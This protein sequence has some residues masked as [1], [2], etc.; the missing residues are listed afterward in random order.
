MLRLIFTALAA[1]TLAGCDAA[2]VSR[3]EPSTSA[4]PQ[5][6]SDARFDAIAAWDEFEALL[7]DQYAYADRFGEEALNAQMARSRAVAAKARSKDEA[8]RIFH[9][10]AL[11]FADPH[12]LVGP[13]DE[14][15]YAVIMTSADLDI[16]FDNGAFLVADVRAGSSAEVAGIRSGWGV[17]EVD[18]NPVD[19]A[20]RLPFGDVLPQPTGEQLAYGATLAANGLRGR[21]RKLTFETVDG[22][23]SF[24]LR[25]T[26]EFALQVRELAPLEA[27]RMGARGDIGYVRFNNRLGDNATIAAFD[28]AISE[29]AGTRALIIDLRNTPSGGNTDVARSIIGHFVDEATAYQMHTIPAVERQTGVPRR[30]VEYVEPRTPFYS[31]DIVVLHGRWT[32]SMGEGLVIGLDAA[33]EATTIGSNMGDLLGALWNGD[34]QISG[35]WVEYGGEALFHPNGSPR[36][37]YVADIPVKPA[38]RDASGDDP[39][40]DEALRRLN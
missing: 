11:T 26:R 25:A 20:A 6:T 2:S 9:Q 30:F 37:N 32:G 39:A 33:T 35:A 14:A 5:S 40:L 10:T 38:D 3:D 36:E 27:R 1:A 13:L 15:D 12:L 19:A 23:R 17:R 22:V 31:G 34:L 8:R 18:G 24:D 7:R 16:S 29:L 21:G 28:E 4:P